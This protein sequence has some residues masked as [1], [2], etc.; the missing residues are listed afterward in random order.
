MRV[1]QQDGKRSRV[2]PPLRDG[3]ERAVEGTPELQVV[4]RSCSRHRAHHHERTFGQRGQ[5]VAQVLTQP[6]LDPV[7]NH[8]VTDALADDDPRARAEFIRRQPAGRRRHV[9]HG[10]GR[11]HQVHDERA[12]TGAAAPGGH[13]PVLGPAA[14][15]RCG[16]QHRLRRTAAR[17]PCADARRGSPGRHGCA[18]AAES[19]ASSRDGGCWAGRCA[20]SRFDSDVFD[21]QRGERE[22]ARDACQHATTGSC[23]TTVRSSRRAGQTHN[24]SES[25]WTEHRL[26]WGGAA[27]V[28]TSTRCPPNVGGC[29]PVALDQGTAVPATTGRRPQP[30]DTGVDCSPCQLSGGVAVPGREEIRARDRRNRTSERHRRAGDLR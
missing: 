13:E 14:D 19:R 10:R 20:C 1:P 17:D 28:P 30:V 2:D 22:A 12:A 4:S 9:Q 24:S 5:T 15:P 3:P 16:G 27:S 25:M 6:A 18:Y 21:D 7:T 11:W 29:A 8:C 23:P 26:R